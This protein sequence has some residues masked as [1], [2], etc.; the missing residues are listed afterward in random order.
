M[1][2]LTI[3]LPPELQGWVDARLA[4][5]GYT[6]AESYVRQLIQH[7]RYAYEAEVQRV[8]KLIDEGLASGVLDAEPEDVLDEIIAGIYDS[9]D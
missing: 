4:K 7:D 3:S 6:D 5:G 2:Q 8:R 1:S 9:N